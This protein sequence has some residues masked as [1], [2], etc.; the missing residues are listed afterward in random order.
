MSLRLTFVNKRS[1]LVFHLEN[2]F[3]ECLQLHYLDQN[4]FSHQKY[5]QV[6]CGRGDGG[7]S[8]CVC[9]CVCV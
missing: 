3:V 4:F 2:L 1:V 6:A 7:A 8:Q 5:V 9:V